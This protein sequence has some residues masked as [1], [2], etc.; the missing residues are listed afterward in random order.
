LINVL[1]YILVFSGSRFSLCFG[2]EG[3]VLGLVYAYVPYDLCV[4]LRHLDKDIKVIVEVLR[5]VARVLVLVAIPDANEAIVEFLER[6][7]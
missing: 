6:P 7:R 4:V 1:A 2:F 5:D 3:T